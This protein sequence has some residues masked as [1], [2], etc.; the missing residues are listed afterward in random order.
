M[1]AGGLFAAAQT[2]AWSLNTPRVMV[3]P[4]GHIAN[5]FLNKSRS[6]WAYMYNQLQVECIMKKSFLR[7]NE[8]VMYVP[9]SRAQLLF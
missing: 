9:K 8:G 4:Q 5:N 3:F 1:T 2:M 6:A 7:Q